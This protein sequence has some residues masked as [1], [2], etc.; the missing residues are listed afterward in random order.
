MPSQLIPLMRTP[1]ASFRILHR[2][3]FHHFLLPAILNS[4]NPSGRNQPS[5]PRRL[6]PHACQDCAQMFPSL[7]KLN[8]GQINKQLKL[9]QMVGGRLLSFDLTALAV[10]DASAMLISTRA[11]IW[12]VVRQIAPANAGTSVFL[13]GS[14]RPAPACSVKHLPFDILVCSW[15]SCR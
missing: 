1:G 15:T 8:K 7:P 5:G 9:G 4:Y 10:S 14:D 3:V 13:G 2:N 6:Q 11:L 12:R